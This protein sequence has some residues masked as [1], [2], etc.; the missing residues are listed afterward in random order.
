MPKAV[1][2]VTQKIIQLSLL[3]GM[4]PVSPIGFVYFGSY[5]A[6]LGDIRGGYHYAKLAISL[7]NVV[8]RE[9]AGEVMIFATQLR[10]YVEPLQA[11]LQYHNEGYAAA[12]ASGNIYMAVVNTYLLNFLGLS[13]GINLQILQEQY[14]ESQKMMEKR[15][16]VI[17]LIQSQQKQ[18]SIF[19]LIGTDEEPKS[20]PEEQ[21]ILSSNNSVFRS[22]CFQKAYISF[23]FRSF[24]E[25]KDSAEKY[26]ACSENTWAH[27]FFAHSIHTFYIGLISFWLARKSRDG[28]QWQ[29]RGEKFRIA[30]K[31]WAE[32]CNWTF[33]N[34]WY[35]LEA[36][37]AYCDNNFDSAEIFFAKAISSAKEHKVS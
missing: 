10:C 8:G 1:P 5:L 19:K 32:Y 4:S 16:Q 12:M 3:H 9:S 34:K 6:K 21:S 26:L 24:D 37:Q 35:L 17:F 20:V 18:R 28:Q 30:L 7:L 11:I 29:Q 31:R 25:T 36:E 22:Y 33:E 14:A 2:S 13:A 27:L 15:K 23:L